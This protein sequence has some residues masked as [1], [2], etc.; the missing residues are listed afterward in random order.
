ME[1]VWVW[2]RIE[3]LKKNTISRYLLYRSCH[4]TL[5]W[6]T[7]GFIRFLRHHIASYSAA[8]PFSTIL[9]IVNRS[10]LQETYK[11]AVQLLTFKCFKFVT[12][13]YTDRLFYQFQNSK[14]NIFILEM[15]TDNC[16]W[17]S[18]LVHCTLDN[19]LIHRGIGLE[20]YFKYP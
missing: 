11:K 10:S 1:I 15:T 7:G 18:T 3:S 16:V 6:A 5:Q 13:Q 2:L 4:V 9:S 8:N 12:V 17:Q 14:H 20:I 19:L